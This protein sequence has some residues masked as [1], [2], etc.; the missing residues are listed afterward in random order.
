MAAILLPPK[1]AANTRETHKFQ[2]FPACKKLTSRLWNLLLVGV[3]LLCGALP[4][5]LGHLQ[6]VTHWRAASR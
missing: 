3:V 1:T 4:F 6:I 2:V 5:T